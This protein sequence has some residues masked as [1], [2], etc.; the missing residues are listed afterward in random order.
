L[1]RSNKLS[2]GYY[3]FLSQHSGGRV[4]QISEFE[5]SLVYRAQDCSKTVRGAG[6]NSLKISNQQN[7]SNKLSKIKIY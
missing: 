1:Y 4:R 7:K 6:R 5:A 2:T 3:T